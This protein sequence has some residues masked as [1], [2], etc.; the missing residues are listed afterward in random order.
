M[1]HKLIKEMESGTKGGI[2]QKKIITYLMHNHSSTIPDLAKDI[3]LSIPT[4]TKFLMELVDAGYI[5]NYGKQETSEGRPPNLYGLNPDSAYMV[6]VDIKSSCLNIGLMNFTGDMID[7]QMGIECRLENTLEGLDELTCH[8]CEFLDKHVNVKD[9]ILQVG[10]NISGRVNP[11]AGYS[12]SMFNFEERPLAEVLYEK[13]GIPV[14]I[15]ND[16][17]AMAYG[18]LLKGAVKGEK[19]I[20]FINISWGLGSAFIIDGKIYTGRSGFSGEFGHFSVFDNEIICRCGKKG[21]LETEVS[22]SALHRILC[23]KVKS[24]QSSILSK[25]ILTEETSVTLEEIVDATNKED[26][27]CIE[28]VEEI[29][30]KLGRYL[31]G[32]INLFNPELVVIGGTLALTE[33]Y[34]LQPIKTAIRKYS[35]NLVS[36]DSAVVLSKLQAKAGVIGACLLSRSKLFEGTIKYFV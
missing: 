15:D 18:E 13:I 11:E 27:L 36:K 30:R 7:L 3:D 29:G 20:V 26:I 9:K 25:R 2:T 22:G 8:I 23:E 34:I 14:S 28:L 12:F 21:C 24:G 5:V 16:T 19:D 32:L 6:G 35:L 17:R 33:D 10:V 31:A 4:V 1:A